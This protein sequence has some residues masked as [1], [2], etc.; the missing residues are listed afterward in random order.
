M[1]DIYII[2]DMTLF[3][4][5]YFVLNCNTKFVTLEIPSWKNLRWEGLYKP[6]PAKIISSIRARKMVWHSLLPYLNDIWN[7]DVGST[8]IESIPMVSKFR[9]VFPIDLPSMTSN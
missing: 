3:S 1:M 8:Y 4:E 6:K 5:Y 7:V 2:L 9:E